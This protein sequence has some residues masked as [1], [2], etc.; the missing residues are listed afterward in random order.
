MKEAHFV[1]TT[2]NTSPPYSSYS[3]P[4]HDSGVQDIKNDYK[5]NKDEFFC[6]RC[7][8]YICN[9]KNYCGDTKPMLACDKCD[10]VVCNKCAKCIIDY[11]F[12][13]KLPFDEFSPL[14][15]DFRLL[16]MMSIKSSHGRH[17]QSASIDGISFANFR[18]AQ[19]RGSTTSD[20]SFHAKC[21]LTKHG[22]FRSKRV[23]S[24]SPSCPP[25]SDSEERQ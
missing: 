20:M 17:V 18:T 1:P 21:F 4:C 5:G 8:E 11:I 24:S 6:G 16:F 2:N 14:H 12:E 15:D 10:L 3:H 9:A 22:I 23:A 13:H 7:G 25:L 19:R